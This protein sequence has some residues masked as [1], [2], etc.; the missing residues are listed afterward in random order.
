VELCLVGHDR[1]PPGK[2]Y[3]LAPW[4]SRTLLGASVCDVAMGAQKVTLSHS[5]RE[6]SVSLA[7]I[8]LGGADQVA[9]YLVFLGQHDRDYPLG[10]R[11]IGWIRRVI[12]K[13]LVEVVDLEKYRVTVGIEC[14]EVVFFVRVVGV[15]EIVVHSDGLDDPFDGFLAERSDAR[16]NDCEAAKKMLAK[17]VVERTNLVGLGGG[18]GGI[19]FCWGYVPIVG[20]PLAGGMS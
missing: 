8:E 10:D 17:L 16:C 9:R 15:A 20:L 12:P 11:G 4:S 7:G 6:P 3:S 18:H 13:C 5:E 2:M 14:T 19:S 1:Q